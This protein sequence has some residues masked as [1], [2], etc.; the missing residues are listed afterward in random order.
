VE[1]FPCKTAKELI[2]EVKGFERQSARFVQD[3]LKRVLKIPSRRAAKKPLLTEKMKKKRLAF[4]KKYI[5][6]TE[7]DWER[8]MYSDESTFRLVN[9][10]SVMVRRPSGIS[11]YKQKY[12]VKTVKHSESVMVWGC[13]SSTVGRGGLFFLPKN[14]MMNSEVYMGVLKDHL[15]P[16]MDI[17][18]STFFL[19]DGAPCHTSKR[20]MA[21]LREKEDEFTVLDWPGNSPDLNPIENV[22]AHMKLKLKSKKVKNMK[23]LKAAITTMWVEDMPHAYFQKLSAS[24][25]KRLK[26]VLESKGDMTKY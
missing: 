26:L 25:P 23:E 6:W 21:Y 14:Q 19:Q 12:T 22:W 10:R 18:G 3:R 4:A 20:V 5:S 9:P 7:S 13:F 17:H 11:R 15:F 2:Q 16:F 1:K 8:V 24:M